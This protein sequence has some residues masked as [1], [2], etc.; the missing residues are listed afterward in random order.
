MAGAPN[1][2]EE[3]AHHRG[4]EVFDDEAIETLARHLPARRDLDAFA[5]GIRIAAFFYFQGNPGPLKKVVNASKA[6]RDEMASLYSAAYAKK[7]ELLLT[8]LQKLSAEAR[9]NIEMRPDGALSLEKA[10]IDLQN[11][12]TRDK[13]CELI[14]SLVSMGGRWGKPSS[15]RPQGQ[16]EPLLWAPDPKRN[17]PKRGEEMVFIEALRGAWR[18][19]TSKEAARTAH[20]DKPGPFARLVKECLT[21]LGASHADAVG[22]IN[23]ID[24]LRRH[25]PKNKDDAVG[26]IDRLMR[27]RSAENT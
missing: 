5:N 4:A 7:H 16:W 2:T 27:L 20:P 17:F 26:L 9:S 11:R 18:Q 3:A 22:L 25:P 6:L 21:L 15:S 23:E 13:A 14:V 19:A 10:L 1:A 24:R 8:Q 12:E